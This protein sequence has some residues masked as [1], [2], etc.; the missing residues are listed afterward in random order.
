MQ[1]VHLHNSNS[2]LQEEREKGREGERE[3]KV[4]DNGGLR[5][6]ARYPTRD[7][8]CDLDDEEEDNDDDDDDDDALSFSIFSLFFLRCPFSRTENS[9]LRKPRIE[10]LLRI[11]NPRVIRSN[12]TQPHRRNFTG[13]RNSFL[14]KISTDILSSFSDFYSYDRPTAQRPSSPYDER[15]RKAEKSWERPVVPRIR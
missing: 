7:D 13:L 14:T 2:L 5:S 11:R 8:L 10:G 3:R 9:K 12:E 6:A 15:H 4:W 1:R